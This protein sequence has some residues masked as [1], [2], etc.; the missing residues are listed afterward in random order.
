MPERLPAED[1]VPPG[2]GAALAATIREVVWSA[3]RREQMSERN[4]AVA[5]LYAEDILQPRRAQF[6]RHIQAATLGN[7]RT[8][9][10]GETV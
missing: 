9:A 10:R 3:A 2:D 1:L 5:R 6:Y 8:T 7:C 4:I